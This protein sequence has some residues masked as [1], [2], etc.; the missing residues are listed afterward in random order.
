[1]ASD[2]FKSVNIYFPDSDKDLF[3]WVKGQGRGNDSYLGREAFE[4]LRLFGS[5]TEAQA[6]ANALIIVRNQ[7][8]SVANA[9]AERSDLFKDGKNE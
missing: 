9:M 4:C 5:L 8:D 7:Y 6:A 2:K 3:E 1:M